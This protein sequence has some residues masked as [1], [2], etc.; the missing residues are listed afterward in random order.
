MVY[1]S[2]SREL[3]PFVHGILHNAT[4]S[5]IP[6]F[7]SSSPLVLAGSSLARLELVKVPAADG[8]VALVLVH[9]APEVGDVLCAHARGLVLRV[10]GGLAV[11]VLG[12]R[13]VDRR[14]GCAGA[15]AE[16]TTNG[17]ADGRTDCD[18]AV[19]GVSSK[20]SCWSTSIGGNLR[21]SAGHLA[22]Q[23]AT[24]ARCGRGLLGSGGRRGVL[25]RRRL[26]D[27]AGLAG[28]SRLLGRRARLRSRDRGALGRRG[29]TA[30]LARHDG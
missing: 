28:L 14:S 29:G 27:G 18:T 20:L 12:E 13:L 25:V 19:R 23:T 24:T 1:Y 4:Q 21:S 26:S 7:Y 16:P 15:A 6:S 9:A 10:H 30:G 2:M 22:E 5:S 3:R 11:L 8:E 17:V